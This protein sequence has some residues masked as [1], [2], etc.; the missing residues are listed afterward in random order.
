MLYKLR[1]YQQ[2]AVDAVI[3]CFRSQNEPALVVLPTGAGKSLVI[4]ELARMATGRVLVLAHVKEL[5][6]QNYAKYAGVREASI[7]SAGLGRKEVEHQVVFGG[8][9]SVVRNLDAFSDAGFTLVIIDECHRV[10]MDKDSSYQKVLRHLRRF[11]PQLKLL[12]LTAT[13]YRLGQGWIYQYLHRANGQGLVRTTEERVFRDCIYELSLQRMI[14]QGY[15][16][17][18]DVVDAPFEAYDFSSLSSDF[19]GRISEADLNKELKQQQRLTPLIVQQ[20]MQE[21]MQR[22]GVLIYAATVDHAK[23]VLSY[24]PAHCSAMVIGDTPGEE[25]DQIIQRFKRQELI[26]L[27][28]VAVFTTGFD[29]PHVD[30]LV[31]M[32][33]TASVSL[34]QQICGRGLRLSPGKTDCRIIDYAGNRYNLFSPEVGSSR[35]SS[36]SVAVRV[37]CPSCAHEN[38]FWGKTDHAGNVTEHYGRR[39]QAWRSIEG[40]RVQC[41]FR[42]RFKV[43]DRCGAEND[44]AARKCHDCGRVI[45]DPD[46][47]LKDAMQLKNCLILRCVGVSYHVDENR[48]GFERL[49]VTYHDEDGAEVSEFFLF[50]TPGQCGAFYHRFSKQALIDR[51]ASFRASSATQVAKNSHLFRKPD[52]V[53][54]LKEKKFWKVHEKMYDYEGK[55]KR[56]GEL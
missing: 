16:T 45:V 24:L 56:G 33:P 26:F 3:R 31:I 49:R 14:K 2:E 43:C 37:P 17:P 52:F 54:A 4:S 13:P 11:N 18:P 53:I 25:R 22:K 20:V 55:R 36:D 48:K 44:I 23:E 1:P 41:A 27:V 35:P 6:E 19:F 7:F 21:A 38:L 42:F 39:C 8:V 9:Q 29:A 30:L 34:Y 47:K 28:N 32:R 15:L 46:Q 50:E 10:S 40:R 51:T 5:V 12:G